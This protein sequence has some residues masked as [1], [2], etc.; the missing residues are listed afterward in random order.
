MLAA[1]PRAS[2][3]ASDKTL[4]Y[5]VKNLKVFIAAMKRAASSAVR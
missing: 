5:L 4:S 1:S 2:Q 3:S